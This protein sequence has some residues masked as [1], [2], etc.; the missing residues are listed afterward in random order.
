METCG[1]DGTGADGGGPAIGYEPYGMA[2]CCRGFGL[3]MGH[4]LSGEA[5]PVSEVVL[6]R[7]LAAHGFGH[8]CL[9]LEEG[10]G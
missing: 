7:G 6:D 4:A 3:R 9:S 10:L 2:G 8:R 1:T 5:L